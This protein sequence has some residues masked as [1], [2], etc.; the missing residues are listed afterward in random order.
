MGGTMTFEETLDRILRRRISEIRCLR[1]END[2]L[3]A[4]NAVLLSAA[5]GV[6]SAWEGG[7]GMGTLYE[8]TRAIP[9]IRA[10]IARAESLAS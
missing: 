3:R 8:M 1:E 2:E 9:S 10:A 7:S 5:K 4:S 6:L